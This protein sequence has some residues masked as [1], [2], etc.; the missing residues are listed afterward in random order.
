MPR[1]PSYDSL[2]TKHVFCKMVSRRLWYF[3]LV[4]PFLSGCLPQQPTLNTPLME[5]G[6]VVIYLQPM[7]QQASRLRFVIDGISATSED[8][9]ET[10]LLLSIHELKGAEL[11]GLQKRLSSG[12]L[13]SG[14]YKGISIRVKGAFV[15]T[16]EGEASLFVPDEPVMV[17]HRF[18]VARRKTLTLFLS[19]NPFGAITDGIRFTPVFSLRPAGGGLINLAGYV[20]NSGSHT[21]SVFDKKTMQVVDAISTGKGPKGMILD[22]RR[23]RL[24][25]A[26]SGDDAI[27]AIDV[28]K[29]QI[30]GRARLHF[31]DRP[32]DLVLTADGR[33]LVSVNY[34]SNTVSII[35]PLA[36]FETERIRVGEGPISAVLDPSG[37][38]VYTMNSLSKTVSVVDLTQQLLSATL[39][40]EGTPLR[41]EFDRNGNR[42]YVI[43]DDSPYLT[44]IDPSALQVTERILIGM[45]AVSIEMDTQTDLI[46]V[47]M[48]AGHILVIDPL[49]LMPIDAIAVGGSAAFM[50]TDAD[51]HNLFVVLPEKKLLQKVNLTSKKTIAE[52]EVADGA[53]AVV[54]TGER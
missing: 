10:P 1:L 20:S 36:L 41:G 34:G 4:L 54:V 25:V 5:E 9:I 12:P 52:I 29:R 51:E 50:T 38:K 8:G 48:K 23:G 22:S 32:Q 15:Q 37:L 43:S 26:I 27:E 13:G 17:E 7:P 39:P 44:V 30:V 18:K 35:D 33:T 49:A 21:I 19:L 6:Q 47:G 28:A 24:Y 3:L 31:Q 14:S 40:V 11:A 53:H 45:G 16:E 2:G 46:L 42:L